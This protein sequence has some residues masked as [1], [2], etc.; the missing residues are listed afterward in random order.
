MIFSHGL[1]GSRN[2][3]SHIC[4]SLASHGIIVIAPEHRDGSG[5]F[6]VFRT[7]GDKHKNRRVA[8]KNIPH[9]STP[10]VY[11]ARN[12]QLRIRMWELGMI[13]DALTKIDAGVSIKNAA[14]EHSSKGGKDPLGM[15]SNMMDM[16]KPGSIIFGGHSFGACTTIQF[17]K[18]LYYRTDETIDGYTPLYTPSK[19]SSLARQVTPANPVILLDAWTLPVQSP[20]TEWL[21]EKPMPCYD[22]PNGG[23]NLLSVVSDAFYKWSSNFKEVT[24]V[25]AKPPASQS[26]YPNQPGP[27]LFYPPTSAHLSQS[28]F[29]ILFPWVTAK[30]F[31]AKDPERLL[32][33]N[34][35]AVLQVLRE[36]GFEVA[37]TSARD[38]E[39]DESTL[40]GKDIAQDTKI[41]SRT[42]DTVPGWEYLG[43]EDKGGQDPG[44]L[45][46]V[47]V[48]IAVGAPM[49]K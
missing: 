17:V 6:T 4:G 48:Q 26:K 3:Y 5:T 38:L 18:S 39:V 12:E 40:G 20:D 47:E 22:S 44:M 30:V 49:E 35:R 25:I 34:A 14:Q 28:D 27:H 41:L 43:T 46:R 8:Y 31:G 45:D 1:A 37:N 19:D 24:A 10:E 36:S 21:K 7:E 42:K 9:H 33:L 29:G 13:H 32:R 16:H 2:A 23:K 15:F 11:D